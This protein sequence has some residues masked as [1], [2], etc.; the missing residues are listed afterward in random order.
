MMAILGNRSLTDESLTTTMCLV[1]QI[2]N[3]RPIT[4]ASD[5]PADLEALTPNHFILGRAIVC[6]P[7]IP[8]AENYSNHRKMFRSRQAY[9]DMIWKRWV[10]EYLPQTH[11]RTQWSK[12]EANVEV[13]DLVWLVDNNVKRSQ[14]K[15][16]RIQEIYPAKDGVVR[17]VPIKTH[18][19][20]F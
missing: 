14:Y 6:L 4:P 3:A 16:A 7:F 18:D 20:T 5:D 1:E 19:D 13:G 10:A 11:V 15:M 9:A 12:Q 2:L 17:S 8:N